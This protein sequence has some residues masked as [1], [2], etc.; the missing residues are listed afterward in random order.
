M[1]PFNLIVIFSVFLFFFSS[2]A[3]VPQ[4]IHVVERAAT[5]V[6]TDVGEEGDSVGDLL[7]FA[8]DVYDAANE[9]KVGTDNGYCIRTAVAEAWE[10]NWTVTLADGQLTAE[11]PFYDV[12]D[13]VLAITGG[14]GAYKN[15]RG[16]MQ[17]KSRNAEGTEFDFIYEVY[18]YY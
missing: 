15:A 7:T 3:S 9:N 10:C 6:I 16:E 12:A 4:T 14:T 1:K 11:G 5:D 18:R 2:C 13:S 17:L 8:N